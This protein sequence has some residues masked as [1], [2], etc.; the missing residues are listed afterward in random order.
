MSIPSLK[1]VQVEC[2]E[3][4]STHHRPMRVSAEDPPET[5]RK[6]CLAPH[7][8][9]GADFDGCGETVALRV[10]SVEEVDS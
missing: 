1:L 10:L 9:R 4:G 8:M 5:V 7:P 3:C 2:P 6:T